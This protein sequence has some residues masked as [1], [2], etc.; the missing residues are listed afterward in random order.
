MM[1]RLLL[2]F[3]LAFVSMT[4]YATG[5][6]G[7]I[8]C[9]DGVEWNLLGKYVYADK[10]L[11][12]EL[13]EALPKERGW[14]SS[15]YS[16]Y[17][18]YW[19]IQNEH[20]CL[21]SI[22]YEVYEFPTLSRAERLPSETILR[23][24]KKYTDGKHIIASWV[25]GDIRMAKGKK[26]YDENIGYQRN[27]KN[28]RI[29]T[30]DHGRVCGMKDYKNYVDDGF[31]FDN[32][33]P[34][35]NEE[36]HKMFPLHIDQYPELADVKQIVFSIGKAR[37][38]EQGHLVECE[39]KVRK[40]GDNPRLAAEMAEAMKAYHPWR[41]FYINGEYRAYGIEYHTFSYKLCE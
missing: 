31:S 38:D 5:Q 20:L 4:M 1:K 23:I 37:V 17:T 11:A 30:I 19:S 7:D 32:F 40:P 6:D 27:Y 8:I 24:F 35:N 12:R 39:V 14:S 18:A 33:H 41:V 13:R 22:L 3:T 16:G 21:D 2:F 15:N 28:E 25:D 26:L 29:I 9:I 34:E 10:E 36:L